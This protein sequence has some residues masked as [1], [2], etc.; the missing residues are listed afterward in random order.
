MT[1]KEYS[2]WI[3]V[4]K[5]ICRNSNVDPSDLVHEVFIARGDLSKKA[6]RQ[7]FYKS[8]SENNITIQ[9][10]ERFL[11]PRF[12]KHKPKTKVCVTCGDDLPLGCFLTYG[13]GRL[14]SSCKECSNRRSRIHYHNNQGKYSEMH[15]AW[16]ESNCQPRKEYMRK[17]YASYYEQNKKKI[18]QKNACWY[19]SNPDK[20]KLIT[21]KYNKS[22]KAK[23]TKKRYRLK[24]RNADR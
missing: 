11:Q 6:L 23:A 16:R 13:D 3:D 22:D 2:A 21:A 20:R 19:A 5:L 14:S 12:S 10:D 18:A 1:N 4:A 15:K 9:Y 7:F 24:K 8:R 17:Y